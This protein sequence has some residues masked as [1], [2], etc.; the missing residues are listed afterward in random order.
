M[1]IKPN[2]TLLV[3]AGTFFAASCVNGGLGACIAHPSY[4]WCEYPLDIPHELG[5]EPIAVTV[6]TAVITGFAIV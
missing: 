5:P 6:S 3:A 1:P 2:V 4:T